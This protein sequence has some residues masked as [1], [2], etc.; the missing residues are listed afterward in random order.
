MTLNKNKTFDKAYDGQKAYT[1]IKYIENTDMWYV[2]TLA[3]IPNR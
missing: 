3:L 1:Y 2:F